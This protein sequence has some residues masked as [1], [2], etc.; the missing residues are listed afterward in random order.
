VEDPVPHAYSLEVSSPG[1]DRPLRT[2]A[3]FQRYAGQTAKITM[4]EPLDGRKNFRGVIVGVEPPGP[5]AAEVV[6]S[7]D[8]SDF[9]L[10]ISDIAS[11]RLVP[12]WD[13]IMKTHKE[14]PAR[15]SKGQ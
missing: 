13:S 5:E 7:V 6:V 14:S 1:L 11:A 8:G 12:D 10:P 15:R 2:A 4:A 9:R 3:H